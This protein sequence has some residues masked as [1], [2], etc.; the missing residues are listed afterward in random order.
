MGKRWAVGG[1]VCVHPR[2]HV[3]G[4]KAIRVVTASLGDS[5]VSF[6]KGTSSSKI[7]RTSMGEG[8]G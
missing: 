1:G 4:F 2:L 6:N 7:G 5:L 3:T 8:K